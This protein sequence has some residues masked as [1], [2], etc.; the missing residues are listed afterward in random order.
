MYD[1]NSP[2]MNVPEIPI[3]DDPHGVLNQIAEVDREIMNLRK[4]RE[5]LLGAYEGHMKGIQDH[6][7]KVMNVTEE[8][9]MEFAPTIRGRY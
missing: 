5:K 6:W 3:A 4:R 1:D 7:N 9:P 2:Q 8:A